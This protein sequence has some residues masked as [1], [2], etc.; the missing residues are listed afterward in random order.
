MS[1]IRRMAKR[2]KALRLAQGLTQAQLAQR[3][4][5]SRKHVIRIEAAEQEPTL[6]VIERLAKALRVRPAA[7]LE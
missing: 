6:G 1:P 3:A 7:L 5:I 4:G 2:V